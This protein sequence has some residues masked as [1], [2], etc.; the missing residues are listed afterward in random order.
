MTNENLIIELLQEMKQEQQKMNQRL[1]KIEQRLDRVD[2]NINF[3]AA[4]IGKLKMV[5]HRQAMHEK[6]EPA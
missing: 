1:D 6:A 3:L 2:Q 4:E 5:N